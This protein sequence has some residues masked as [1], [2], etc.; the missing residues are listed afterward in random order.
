M[1]IRPLR[2]LI[3]TSNSVASDVVVPPYDVLTAAEALK[4]HTTNPKSLIPVTRPDAIFSSS[5]YISARTAFTDLT[6]SSLT[7]PSTPALYIYSQSTSTHTQHGLVTLSLIS[8]Y[9]SNTIKKHERT[10][11]A[12]EKDRALLTDHLSAQI[13]PIFLTYRDVPAIN[14]LISTHTSTHDPLFDL[15]QDA[16]RHRVWS[17]PTETSDTL[18]NLFDLHVPSAYIADGHHRAASAATVSQQRRK[19][20][21]P[22]APL[23][24]SDY[25]LSVFFPA[26]HLNVLP[27]N[28]IVTDLNGHTPSHFLKLLASVGMLRKLPTDPTAP[29]TQPHVV[30]IYLDAWYQLVLPDNPSGNPADNIDAAILQEKVLAPF[31]AIDDPR[32][33]ER[34]DFVGG[35]KGLSFLADSVKRGDAAV[36]FAL[37]PVSVDLLMQV[38]DAGEIMPPKSTW[39]EPKLRSGFFIHTF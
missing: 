14:Q 23:A 28:R 25:F 11:P 34:I 3:P 13:G 10:R 15:T 26:T 21:P 35:I 7:R 27:Y 33:S 5:T 12:K 32:N 2:P 30:Y 4:I 29:P 18:V 38:A 31:L 17:L 37:S 16:V 19:Q 22:D 20:L 36:A 9:L 24:D 8:D 39:F 6:A 1:H